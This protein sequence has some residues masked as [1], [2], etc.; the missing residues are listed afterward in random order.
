MSI[1]EEQLIIK[2][3]DVKN[4]GLHA[5]PASRI[6]GTAN[7]Y[8]ADVQEL[9]IYL[10]DSQTNINSEKIDLSKVKENNKKANGFSVLSL[11]GLGAKNHS[12]LAFVAK[13]AASA[14]MLAEI[15]EVLIAE[16]LI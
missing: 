6:I 10:L 8:R 9:S 5:R 7:K 11:L 3:N 13:G 15:K 1:K 14:K 16:K 12:V 4:I 2:L